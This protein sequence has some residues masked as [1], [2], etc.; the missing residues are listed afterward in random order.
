M[1][2]STHCVQWIWQRD[3]VIQRIRIIQYLKPPEKKYYESQCQ[4]RGEMK[5]YLSNHHHLMIR[6]MALLMCWHHPS[7]HDDICSGV[8]NWMSST[9]HSHQLH[10]QWPVPATFSSVHQS[11]DCQGQRQS[12]EDGD[13]CAGH[14]VRTIVVTPML[15]PPAQYP[16]RG[17]FQ[18]IL[19]TH[20]T[21][22]PGCPYAHL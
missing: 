6:N 3:L 22:C 16:R 15:P 8:S 1:F 20:G 21:P 13:K 11:G 17:S 10:R 12:G 18:L 14:C 5:W 2:Y 9:S 7:I 4:I 19:Q